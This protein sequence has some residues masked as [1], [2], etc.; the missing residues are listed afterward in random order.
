MF[1]I[2]RRKLINNGLMILGWGG[3]LAILGVLFI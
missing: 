1:T 3:G 2:F